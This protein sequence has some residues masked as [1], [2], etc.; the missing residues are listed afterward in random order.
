[1]IT[2]AEFKIIQDFISGDGSTMSRDAVKAIVHMI[3]ESYKQATINPETLK[4]AFNKELD[5]YCNPAACAGDDFI[6]WKKEICRVVFVDKDGNRTISEPKR[7]EFHEAIWDQCWVL[8]NVSPELWNEQ[9]ILVLEVHNKE[10][11]NG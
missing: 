9:A 10:D 4:K 11:D 8:N 5:A 7:L 1:M 6:I 2:A 3:Y